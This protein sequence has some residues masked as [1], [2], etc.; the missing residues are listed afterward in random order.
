[1]Q[2]GWNREPK[3]LIDSASVSGMSGSPVLYYNPHGH[4]RVCGRNYHFNREVAILAGIYVG[5]LGVGDGTDPQVGT[6]WHS[7]VINE[8]I[9]AQCFERLPHEIQL[10]EDELEL[11]MNEVLKNFSP[12][13][14][15]NIKNPQKPTRHY[16]KNELLKMICGRASPDRALDAVIRVAE[17]YSG[18]LAPEQD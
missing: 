3:F 10:N 13:G 15:E 16:A 8:I 18:P 5:R 2:Q 1:V 12:K 11:H 14:L 17:S 7:S 6:V 9:S 4:L